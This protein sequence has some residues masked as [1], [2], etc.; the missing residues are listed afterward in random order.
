M[1]AGGTDGLYLNQDWTEALRSNDVWQEWETKYIKVFSK[2]DIGPRDT[3]SLSVEAAIFRMA[4]GRIS[5]LS[6]AALNLP[7]FKKNMP[8]LIKDGTLQWAPNWRGTPITA[9]RLA[10]TPW[11]SRGNRIELVTRLCTSR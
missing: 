3:S 1:A 2:H 8:D 4:N 6:A 9:G 11:L 7:I 5:M 10:N